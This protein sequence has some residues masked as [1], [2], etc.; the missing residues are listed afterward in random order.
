MG[1][2]I[3]MADAGVLRAF[4]PNH[5]QLFQKAATI[6]HKILQRESPGNIPVEQPTQF[7]LRLNMKPLGLLGIKFLCTKAT[8]LPKADAT[9]SRVHGTFCTEIHTTLTT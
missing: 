9:G 2:N 4:G 8:C 5:A 7:E 6:A 1:A 3:D